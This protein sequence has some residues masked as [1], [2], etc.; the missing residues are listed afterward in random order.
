MYSTFI[1]KLFACIPF[2]S[3]EVFDMHID[4]L[5]HLSNPQN[6]AYPQD[7]PQIPEDWPTTQLER[8]R[9]GQSKIVLPRPTEPDKLANLVNTLQQRGQPPTNNMVSP[10]VSGQSPTSVARQ[11]TKAQKEIAMHT[12]RLQA[13]ANKLNE[14]SDDQEQILGDMRQV[15]VRLN[16]LQDELQ[17]GHGVTVKI[18]KVMLN[19]AVLATAEVDAGA[20]LLMTCRSADPPHP[21]QEAYGINVPPNSLYGLRSEPGVAPSWASLWADF[22]MVWQEPVNLGTRLWHS[23]CHFVGQQ[24]LNSIADARL[25]AS[26][27]ANPLL[28]PMDMLLWFGGGFIG[29]LAL[30]LVLSAFPGLWALAVAILT[31]MTAYAL[32]QATLAPRRNFALAYRIFFMIAGLV[33]GG[34]F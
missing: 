8:R 34:Q 11:K 3:Q 10:R 18:P 16:Q 9:Q 20:N 22:G 24:S 5:S 1:L 6:A 26:P 31:G 32:Y 2:T 13:L 19:E 7:S 14:L 30:T 21:R 25:G 23:I 28:S 27:T 15:E 4:Q 17:A 12:Q 33:I 29:R